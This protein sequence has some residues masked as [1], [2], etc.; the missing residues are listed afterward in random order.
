MD[1]ARSNISSS[2]IMLWFMVAALIPK[3]DGEKATFVELRAQVEVH[4]EGPRTKSA[5]AS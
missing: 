3:C 4:A 5:E 2:P 1:A